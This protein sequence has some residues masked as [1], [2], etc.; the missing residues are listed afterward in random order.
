MKKVFAVF[1]I[2]VLMAI[3]NIFVSAQEAKDITPFLIYEIKDGEVA[4]NRCDSEKATGDFYIPEKIEGLPVTK[5]SENA[6]SICIEIT[7]L[8][9]PDTVKTIGAWAF[10]KCYGLEKIDLGKGVE[11]IGEEAFWACG[12]KEINF[13]ASV[14]KIE[15]GRSVF[16]EDFP[17]EKITVDENNPYYYSENNCL[18]EK[19]SKTLI[20]GCKNSII[21]E[22]ITAIADGAFMA[23]LDVEEVVL[24]ETIKS[25]GEGAFRYGGFKYITIPEGITEIKSSTFESCENLEIVRLPESVKT[26]SDYAFMNC[27]KLDNISLPED[28][29]SIGGGAF[30]A[31][32]IKRIDIPPN[33][34]TMGNTELFAFDRCEELENISVDK[35]NPIYYSENNCLIEKERQ[36]L[37]LG[38]KNSIIPD[39][40]KVIGERAFAKAPIAEI[41]IPQSVETIEESAFSSYK[42]IKS[43]TY[44]GTKQQFEQIEIGE[45]NE[46]IFD[47]VKCADDITPTP[48]TTPQAIQTSGANFDT[49]IFLSVTIVA[50]VV[51]MVLLSYKKKK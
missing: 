21:P 7:S 10:A 36:K 13:P 17:L 5:I 24:P 38:C 42:E 30:H 50:L 43:V 27:G 3:N 16:F 48:E 35:E 37:I 8:V 39:G 44:S 23:G 31:T 14:K 9:I 15:I 18:I 20:A 22:N 6:F 2:F 46:S 1:L 33:L 32:A 11:F 34:K 41:V 47:L 28:L 29:E 45:K 4:I 25:I 40:V 26:I 49:I 19:E 12:I 51:F